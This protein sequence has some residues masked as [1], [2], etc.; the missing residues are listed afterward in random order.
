[1]SLIYLFIMIHQ[2][3]EHIGFK[4]DVYKDKQQ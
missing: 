2:Q 3:Y 1:M 4:Y